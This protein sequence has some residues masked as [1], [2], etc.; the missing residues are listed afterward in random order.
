MARIAKEHQEETAR[1][2]K[3]NEEAKATTAAAHAKI[4]RENNLAHKAH[5]SDLQD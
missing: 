5:V 3:A 1:V 2:F 4:L